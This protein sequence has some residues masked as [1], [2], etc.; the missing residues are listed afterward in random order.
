[1]RPVFS[2]WA[3][4][5][6]LFFAAMAVVLTACGQSAE[7]GKSQNEGEIVIG[8]Q[9]PLTGDYAAEGQ[10]FKKATTLIADEVNQKGGISGKKVRLIFEDDK[11]LPNEST[12]AAQKLVSQGVVATVGSYNSTATEAAQG[13]FHDAHILHVT[14]SSTAVHLT[15]K[16]YENFFRLCFLDSAQGEFAANLLVDHLKAKRVAIVHDNSTYAKGLA[17]WTQKF[18]EQKGGQVVFFDA[19]NPQENDYRALLSKLKTTDPEAIYFT[20]YFSQAGLLLKQAR[21]LKIEVPIAGGNANNNEEVIK[22]AGNQAEGFIV[23]TEPAPK[24]LPYPE[25]KAFVESYKKTYHEDPVSIWTL[26]SADALR[27]ILEAIEKSGTTKPD[28]LE[29]YLHEQLNDF[30]GITG[31]VNFDER[32]DRTGTVYAAYRVENGAFTLFIEPSK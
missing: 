30:P 22:I 9:G 23:T 25:A 2:R 17:D 24:D 8:V 1:M 5:T 31:P 12:L 4:R 14:P 7:T 16:G 28:V 15:E 21:D 10:G 26:M 11:G 32:G 20:G 6:P 27:V 29:K 19:I 3:W 13:V 18:V